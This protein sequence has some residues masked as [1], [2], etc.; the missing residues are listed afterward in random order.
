MFDEATAYEVKAY[1][2]SVPVFWATLYIY[3]YAVKIHSR[4]TKLRAR[5]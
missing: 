5:F 2:K 4:D 3:D 1:K